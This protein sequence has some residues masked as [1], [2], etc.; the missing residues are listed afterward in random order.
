MTQ[1]DVSIA[2]M[3]YPVYN[4][5][6][7]VITTSVT[8]FDLHDLSRTGRTFGVKNL[9]ISTPSPEQHNMVNYIQDYWQEGY[10]ATYNPDR[11][12]AF[13]VLVPVKNI[14]ESCLTIEK[15]SG[16]RPCLIATS[17]KRYERSKSYDFVA[18]ELIQ[19]GDRPVLLCFGTGHGLTEEFVEHCDYI[20]D[21]IEGSKDFNHLPVRAAVAII[22]D[23]LLG[24]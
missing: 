5:H 16:N 21:P 2:L 20:L 14:E 13:N 17:A 12:E 9:F 3:H 19:Q 1:N 18:K 22:L 4:K 23:R 6:G 7:S 15:Q 11:K 24:R 10:G 8:N